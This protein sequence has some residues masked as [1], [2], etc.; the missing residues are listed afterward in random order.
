MQL[1]IRPITD[2]EFR[3]FKNLIYSETGIFLRETKKEL[4]NSRLLRRLK[5]LGFHSFTEY[6]RYIM[7]DENTEELVFMINSIT[8]NKTEFYREGR[9]FEY[10]TDNILPEIY[11]EGEKSGKRTLRIWSAA[12]STGEEPYT[13]AIEVDR[14]FKHMNSWEVRILASDIDTVVLQKAAEGIYNEQQVQPI[15]YELLKEHF[16]K[17]QG[18]NEGRY[19]VKE[20][21]KKYIT[22]RKINLVQDEY[23]IA[24]ELDVIFCRNVFI[25]FNQETRCRILENFHKHLRVGGYLFL[26]YSETLDATGKFKCCFK[27]VEHAVYKKILL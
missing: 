14:F 5:S 12:C 17:G 24:S 13:I 27:A 16:Y 7:K 22:F 20:K 2:E 19:K 6:Y 26:G 1:E 3:R 8:T 10:L 23:P 21:L 9:H 11:S 25:Y 4:I 18:M 15:S